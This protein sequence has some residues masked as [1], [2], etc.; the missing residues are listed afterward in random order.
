MTWSD[1]YLFCFL[2]GF[3]LSVLSFLA[4]AVHIHLPV[5]WHL[6]FHLGHHWGG[7]HGAM[8]GSF[9]G[10]AHISWFNASTIMA[11]LAWFGGTGYLLTRHSHLWALLSLSLATIAGLLAGWVVFRFMVKLVQ[12]DDAPMTSEDRR[13]EGALATISMPIRENGTGEIIFALGGTRR[14]AGA[15]TGDGQPIEKGTE[16]VIERYEKGIAYVKRWEEFSK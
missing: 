6:P 7:G 15:R 14:C 11:F 5:K 3:S 16:V 12:V 2:V 1:F 9:K 8:R 13:V 10:G 4:G